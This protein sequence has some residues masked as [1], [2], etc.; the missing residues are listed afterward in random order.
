[1][2]VIDF[3]DFVSLVV[4]EE[5]ATTIT[6]SGSKMTKVRHELLQS[7]ISCD[8]SPSA[9][10]PYEAHEWYK[11]A[12]EVGFKDLNNYN[13]WQRHGQI[14]MYSQIDSIGYNMGV[15]TKF[16]TSSTAY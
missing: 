6:V 14:E 15:Y 4:E 2:I 16:V 12:Q 9:I 1:M 11:M 8:F 13:E 7:G 3:E 10:Y 5:S